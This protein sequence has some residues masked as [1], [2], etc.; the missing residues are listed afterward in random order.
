MSTTTFDG[1]GPALGPVVGLILAL[2][3]ALVA[4]SAAIVTKDPAYQVTALIFAAAFTAGAFVLG[5]MLS[6][7]RLKI[8]PHKYA[9]GVIKAGVIATMFWGIAGM[10]VGVIIALPAVLAEPVLLSRRWA[11]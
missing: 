1:E 7:G 10:L 11:S 5:F 8:D 9:D 3:G 4:V 2:L 6:E